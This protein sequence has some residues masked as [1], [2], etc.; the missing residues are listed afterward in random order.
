MNTKSHNKPLSIGESFKKF[1]KDFDDNTS[2]V[3]RDS[4]WEMRDGHYVQ[5]TLYEDQK[6]SV[7]ETNETFSS[8]L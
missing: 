8:R 3:F 1:M 6:R 2:K 5:F 4:S 7:A